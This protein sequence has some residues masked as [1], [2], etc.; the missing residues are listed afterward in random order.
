MS[1][2]STAS[3]R[4][5]QRRLYPE[6]VCHVTRGQRVLYWQPVKQSDR[7]QV[8]CPA[9]L[10]SISATNAVRAETH[11]TEAL[12]TDTMTSP[13]ALGQQYHYRAH[14]MAAHYVHAFRPYLS[15]RCRGYGYDST[16]ISMIELSQPW[17]TDSY[18][19][20]PPRCQK[21]NVQSYR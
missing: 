4:D 17:A 11:D 19:G 13:V 15:A 21:R 12:N 20:F 8:Q 16:A 5:S 1:I 6:P 9:F 10:D 7:C 14:R 2:A 18:P 3:P